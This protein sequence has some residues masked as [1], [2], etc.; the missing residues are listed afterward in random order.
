MF[1]AKKDKKVTLLIFYHSSV[2]NRLFR[3]FLNHSPAYYKDL[4]GSKFSTYKI[5]YF[6][7]YDKVSFFTLFSSAT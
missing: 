2:T 6:R 7:I 1:S 3:G 4:R 5:N